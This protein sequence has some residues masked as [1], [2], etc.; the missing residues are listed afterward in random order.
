MTDRSW[1]ITLWQP[2][3]SLWLGPKVHETRSWST[4]YRGLLHVHAS[5]RPIRRAEL[6][7]ELIDLCEDEFG[8]HFWTELPRGAVVG[9]VELVDCLPTVP[10]PD[11][12]LDENDRLCGDFS[13]G[14]FAW[15]RAPS[16]T[17]IGPWP[18]KGKQGLFRCDDLDQVANRELGIA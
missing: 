7:D 6:S 18:Y 9:I 12:P 10:T 11:V 17:H 15:R 16:P 14:R 4:K 3:A 5:V 13:P 8:G 2:W 1:A